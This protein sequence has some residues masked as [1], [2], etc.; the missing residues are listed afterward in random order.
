MRNGR[1]SVMQVVSNLEIGGAQEVVRTLAENLAEAGC[2]PVVCAFKDGPLR[3]DIERLGI[4]VEL[5]PDRRYSVVAFPLFIG[6]MLRIRRALVDVVNRHGADVVQTHLL[7]SLDFLVLTL[8]ARLGPLVFWTVQNANFTLRE[9]HLPKHKW[10]LGPKR[11]G[12]RML[13][14]MAVRWLDGFIAVSDDV[15]TA[16][17]SG[18]GSI[19]E[20]KIAVIFNSVDVRR[21]QQ[22]VDRAAVRR[23][24]G[25]AEDARVI[26]VVATFK[27]QKGHRFLIEAAPAVVARF[28]DLRILLIGDGELREELQEQT[29]ALGMQDHIHFLGSRKDVPELLAASDY[30]VLP[31]LWEGLSMA[32]VEAMAT[33]LPV[34]ATGV[35][36]T[37]QV[38]VSGETGLLIPPGDARR[39]GEA[40][41][42]LLSTPARARA[43]G[44]AAR[45]RVEQRFS[46]QKQVEDH[47]A[48]YRREQRKMN[49]ERALHTADL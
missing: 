47:I 21:Y 31:S 3:Q 40:M 13:Y 24:L 11:L 45:R 37:N 28:P 42:E 48:L 4:P 36:G 1:L 9:D 5:L 19:P 39:L 34:I 44:E 10:L 23:Q 29:R 41:L 8:R 38:M 17:L 26:A 20:D 15:K 27:R 35:S 32:L 12:Y 2:R 30:F 22:P 49:M 14:R 25:L 43:M 7:M 46:A 33:G 16:I 18:I 6:D